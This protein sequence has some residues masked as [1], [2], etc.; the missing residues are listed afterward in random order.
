MK[1]SPGLAAL[2]V[3]GAVH[4][5]QKERHHRQQKNVALAGLQDRWLTLLTTNPD[6]AAQWKP[7]GMNAD[8]F[9]TLLNANQQLCALTLRYRLGLISK[10]RLRFVAKWL[11]NR[12]A[13]RRYWEEFGSFR[14]EETLGDKRATDVNEVMADAYDAFIR[15]V[16]Q[17]AGI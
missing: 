17:A 2:A 3:I 9:V 1:T 16:K 5:V 10:D 7:K 11:M 4:L 13:V 14:E 12:E 15:R 6:L 8:E